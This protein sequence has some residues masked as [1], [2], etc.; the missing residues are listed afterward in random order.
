M[1]ERKRDADIYSVC[2]SVLVGTSCSFPTATDYYDGGIIQRLLNLLCT[3]FRGHIIQ[4]PAYL[5]KTQTER[6]HASLTDTHRPEPQTDTFLHQQIYSFFWGGRRRKRRR[7]RRNTVCRWKKEINFLPENGGLREYTL[8]D[9]FT[10]TTRPET[11]RLYLY[12]TGA[13]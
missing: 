10:P 7:R 11:S 12:N 2:P 9:G 5:K 4:L 6:V 8:S 13:R 3:M 1:K